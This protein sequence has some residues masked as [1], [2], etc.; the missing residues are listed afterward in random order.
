MSTRSLATIGYEGAT[1]ASFLDALREAGI[2]LLVDVRAV[3]ERLP[4]RIE[5]LH[6]R[7]SVD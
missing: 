3:A 7:E 4:V 1:P 6:P 2:A 5:H